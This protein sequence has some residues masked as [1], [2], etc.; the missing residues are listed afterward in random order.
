[1]RSFAATSE[2][3]PQPAT[4]PAASAE[5]RG[6]PSREQASHLAPAQQPP[7]TATMA[8]SPRSAQTHPR[9]N[10][11]AHRSRA[12]ETAPLQPCDRDRPPQAPPDPTHRQSQSAPLRTGADSVQF[13]PGTA[14]TIHRNRPSD[15][16]SHRPRL[17]S[18]HGM[19]LSYEEKR[20]SDLSVRNPA[21]LFGIFGWLPCS[22][23][24]RQGSV[25][26]GPLTP[27]LRTTNRPGEP[28]PCR[29]A[30]KQ[31]ILGKR[32]EG[33]MRRRQPVASQHEQPVPLQRAETNEN[34][35]DQSRNVDERDR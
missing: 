28:R 11:A 7:P 30:E 20:R 18:H 14:D 24:R 5:T 10:A 2:C 17:A 1:M 21:A 29:S 27:H 31:P 33:Q 4:S 35:A 32:D 23:W 22:E 8:T 3:G 12:H 26:L 25:K 15:F 13:R 19:S 9:Q 6:M 34:D 16:G